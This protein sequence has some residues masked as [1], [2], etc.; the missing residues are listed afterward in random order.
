LAP[1]DP[2]RLADAEPAVGA[3]ARL[4]E[5][6]RILAAQERDRASGLHFSLK[7]LDGD[8]DRIKRRLDMRHVDERDALSRKHERK[9]ALARQAVIFGFL[10]E[11]LRDLGP[12]GLK[13]LCDALDHYHL[14]A[15][16]R[17]I[18]RLAAGEGGI[19]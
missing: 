12:V 3:D 11:P 6:C 19:V 4:T 2:A 15:V 18:L 17:A 13:R 16:D 7:R 5:G 14:R 8:L 9:A 1:G 10:F